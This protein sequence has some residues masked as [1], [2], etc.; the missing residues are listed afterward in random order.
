[1]NTREERDEAAVDSVP[2]IDSQLLQDCGSR[3][4][5][6]GAGLQWLPKVGPCLRGPDS[7][8]QRRHPQE[9]A[10]AHRERSRLRAEDVVRIE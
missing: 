1:M 9:R 7:D 10:R 5:I 4:P 6:V 2:G 8:V 3:G